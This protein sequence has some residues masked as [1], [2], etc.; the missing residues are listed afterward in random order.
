MIDY[1]KFRLGKLRTPEFAHV[2]Y[3]W[4]WPIFGILFG[5]LERVWLRESYHPMYSPLDDLIPFCELFLIPYLFWFVFLVGIHVYTLLFDIPAFKRLMVFIM[6]SYTLTIIIYILYPNCQELRPASF[7]RD[8]LFTRIMANYYDFDTNTN[9]CPSLHVIGSVATVVGAWRS[10]HFS[11]LGWR[12][13]F[14]VAAFL[15][16]ISTVFLKQHSILDI[17]AALPVCAV[18]CVAVWLFSRHEKKHRRAV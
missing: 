5:I 4:Y 6:V 7:E 1:R 9:V 14:S 13:A 3:L 8:N 15:I 2:N 10:R 12:I 16:G 18:A 11:G 17:L